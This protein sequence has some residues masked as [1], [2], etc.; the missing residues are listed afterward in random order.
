MGPL[1]A[2]WLLVQAGAVMT[3]W[4]GDTGCHSHSL[5]PVE[6]PASSLAPEELHLTHAATFLPY[7]SAAGDSEGE[8]GKIP[9]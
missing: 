3:R 2:Q 7:S 9:P 5:E 4:A 8:F 1:W 6:P